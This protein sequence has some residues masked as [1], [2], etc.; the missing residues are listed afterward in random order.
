MHFVTTTLSFKNI[1]DLPEWRPVAYAPWPHA[2]DMN[3]CF[4]QRNGAERD[5]FLYW[6]R[7]G[8]A[9]AMAQYSPLNNE[10]K[11]T[12]IFSLPGNGTGDFGFFCPTHGPSGTIG[13]SPTTTSVT[14]A[15][16]PNSA[17]CYVNQFANKGDGVG[18]KIRIIDKGAGG[19]G[20]I[21]ERFIVANTSSTTPVVYWTDALS[22]T[23]AAGSTY[24]LL[25]GRVY[26]LGA[27][28]P[29]TFKCWD[30]ATRT[31]SAALSVTNLPSTV[32]TCTTGVLLDEQY[33]PYDRKAGEGFIVGSGTYDG[34]TK[35]CLTATAI[36]AGTITGQATGGDAGVAANRY[37][38]FQIR[39][40]EDTTNTTAVGQRRKITSHTAGAS[41]V[42]TLASNWTVTP[43]ATCKFVIE[44]NND[45]VSWIAS[46]SVTYS[47]AAGGYAA[48]ANWSTAAVA[49]GATQYANPAAGVS[50]GAGSVWVFGIEPTSDFGVTNAMIYRF[51]GG[52]NVD[53]FDISGGATGA[54]SSAIGYEA[55]GTTPTTGYSYAYDGSTNTGRYLYVSQNIGTTSPLRH[56][57]FDLISRTIEPFAYSDGL[58]P[59]TAAGGNRMGLA[60]FID[61]ATKLASLYMIN[62]SS[63]YMYNV[64]LQ[65]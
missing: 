24:E 14:L 18:Y 9:G 50:G 60:L 59:G 32:G 45:F 43:S 38:N 27:G 39:V 42:Y 8:G 58:L 2:A 56:S 34:A 11:Y 19:S 6:Y 13:A 54:W 16:L 26:Y 17:T 21:E 57:R 3:L 25:S 41:P 35:Y 62:I 33:V 4:D 64:F 52:A 53:V 1:I 51:R 22:F 46:N 40:V 55:F 49:G 48:D 30:I 47:Y 61:G 15:A 29:G 65:R 28:T 37:R 36:A 20:K 23:P 7:I 5:P 31:A 44:G 63:Q 12:G 10:W